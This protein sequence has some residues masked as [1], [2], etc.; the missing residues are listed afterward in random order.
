[1][2]NGRYWNFKE[3]G[4]VALTEELMSEEVMDLSQERIC[5]Q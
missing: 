4:L 3:E 2:E 5:K 1:M